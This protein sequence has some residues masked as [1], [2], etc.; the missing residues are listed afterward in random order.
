MDSKAGRIVEHYRCNSIEWDPSGRIVATAVMQPLEGAFFKYQMDNG[1]KLWTFQGK[2]YHE[3]SYENF[4]QFTWRPRPSSLLDAAQRKAVV[5]NLRKYERK[6]A[7][8]DKQKDL[9]RI[10]EATVEKRATRKALRDLMKL[11]AANYA[12]GAAARMRMRNGVDA[13][14][15]D[16]YVISTRT[17]ESVVRTKEE[18][19]N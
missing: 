1:F 3:T 7:H 9:A 14:A 17:I 12:A 16:L 19:V 10:R 5:K 2:Q 11:R 8:E 18:V 4:Y 15:D 13:D 6:F